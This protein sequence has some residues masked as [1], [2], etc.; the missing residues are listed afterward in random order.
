MSTQKGTG[1]GA[2]LF[3]FTTVLAMAGA[4]GCASSGSLGSHDGLGVTMAQGA[5]GPHVR[6]G[7]VHVVASHVNPVAPVHLTAEGGE[8]AVRFTRPRMGGAVAHLDR[9]SLAAVGVESH[10]PAERWAA[11]STNRSRVVLNDGRFVECWKSGD[12]ERGYRLMAQAWTAGGS[13][14][15]APVTLSPQSADVLGAP[16]MISVDG[17]HAVATFSTVDGDETELL[18]VEVQV[19]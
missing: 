16:Q 3:G 4:T 10:A 1:F 19:L 7:A 2:V 15:G 8:I 5:E 12:S 18:A 11:P 9:D 6:A 13:R 14:L 17:D